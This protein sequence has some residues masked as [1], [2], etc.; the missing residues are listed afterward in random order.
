MLSSHI[1]DR[2]RIGRPGGSLRELVKMLKQIL[3]TADT[4][5]PRLSQ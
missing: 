5:I 4:L 1:Q 2:D 3:V